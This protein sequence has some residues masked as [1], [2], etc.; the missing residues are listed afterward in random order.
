[1]TLCL[2]LCNLYQLY[3]TTS[4]LYVITAN[5][6][7]EDEISHSLCKSFKADRQTDKQTQ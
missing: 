5:H 2:S 1:M 3:G 6:E 4:G 7:L